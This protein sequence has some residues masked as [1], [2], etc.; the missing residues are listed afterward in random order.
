MEEIKE[1]FGRFRTS[2]RR[3]RLYRQLVEYVAQARST[4][5][6]RALVIDGSFVTDKDE[7]GDIDLVVVL[8]RDL[9]AEPSP[10]PHVYNVI[11]KR[12]VRKRF[13][14]DLFV[15]RDE[16]EELRKQIEFFSQVKGRTDMRKGLLRVDL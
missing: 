10:G 2:D 9:L 4:G 8:S 12:R 16:S 1:R 14:F 11:S 15:A 7:P 5:E 6:V 13:D 3:W